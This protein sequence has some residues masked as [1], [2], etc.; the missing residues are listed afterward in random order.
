MAVLYAMM[1]FNACVLWVGQDVVASAGDIQVPPLGH[2]R[3]T[4]ISTE[5]KRGEHTIGLLKFYKLPQYSIS[6]DEKVMVEGVG[7]F[8]SAQLTFNSMDYYASLSS[9]AE[10]KALQAQIN[11]HF[12][13]NALNTISSM[14]R[15]EPL[16]ARRLLIQL[17]NY[18]RGTIET[19][20]DLID[21][22]KE[23][24]KLHGDTHIVFATAYSDYAVDAFEVE[25]FDYILKPFEDGYGFTYNYIFLYLYA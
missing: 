24:K 6:E 23:I 15:I 3:F 16:T 21:I 10:L 14:C 11:P 7:E 8:I 1:D 5:I 4:S 12:L 25:A 9:K 22:R 13:F 18:L 20:P 19:S 17:S 2:D